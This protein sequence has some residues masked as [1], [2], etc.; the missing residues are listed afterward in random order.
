[1]H[2]GNLP[3][4]SDL[5]YEEATDIWHVTKYAQAAAILKSPY[6]RADDVYAMWLREIP[7]KTGRDLDGLMRVLSWFV[8]Q[9]E[10]AAHKHIRQGITATASALLSPDMAELRTLG[11][12]LCQSLQ[13][14]M[15]LDAVTDV[16]ELYYNAQMMKFLGVSDQDVRDARLLFRDLMTFPFSM[17]R[18]GWFEE[19]NKTAQR[20]IERLNTAE[21]LLDAKQ[22]PEGVEP[23][24]V[25]ASLTFAQEAVTALT[26]RMLI[27]LAQDQALQ[28]ELR[29]NPEKLGD[30]VHETLRLLTSFRYIWRVV[31]GGDVEVMGKTFPPGTRFKFDLLALNL[32]MASGTDPGHF[33]LAPPRSPHVSFALGRHK[34]MGLKNTY[35]SIEALFTSVLNQFEIEPG[36]EPATYGR[37]AVVERP[38]TAPII[39]RRVGSKT[40][41]SAKE[42]AQ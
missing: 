30:F 37:I 12:A 29:Q 42:L 27:H 13:P 24:H 41:A 31:Q 6:A 1:M 34:C 38:A 32:E 39:L 35:M 28:S 33:D 26:A 40:N 21:N 10:G 9:N 23:V 11:D 16:A 2:Q 8:F 20:V 14:D 3:H 25:I 18:L 22:M 7:K 15:P 4:V 36:P 19:R 5:Y 17:Q